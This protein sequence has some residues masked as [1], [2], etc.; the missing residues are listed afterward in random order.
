MARRRATCAL[1][2]HMLRRSKRIADLAKRRLAATAITKPAPRPRRRHVHRYALPAEA[3]PILPV[4]GPN[5][6]FLKLPIGAKWPK[7]TVKITIEVPPELGW[8]EFGD[9]LQIA[10]AEN[11]DEDEDSDDAAGDEEEKKEKKEKADDEDD[12]DDDDEEEEEDEDED[13]DEDEED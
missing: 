5:V 8:L 7:G 1:P 12:D 13:E 10:D 11:E 2:P 4:L 9:E 6:P 3:I